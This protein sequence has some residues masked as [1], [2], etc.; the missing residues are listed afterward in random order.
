MDMK[1]FFLYAIVIAALAL[2]GCGGNGGGGD[3]AGNGEQPMSCPDGQTGTPP[4]CVTPTP[5]TCLE[6]P[7]AANCTGFTQAQIDAATKAAGTKETAIAMESMQSAT[8]GTP[9]TDG[10]GGADAGL[11]GSGSSG[12]P[13]P[14]TGDGSYTLDIKRDRDATTVSVTVEGPDADDDADDE[15]FV[16]A[17][18]L[19]GGT[20]MHTRMMDAD[21]DG[22]VVEEVVIVTTD[23][24][25]PKAT[26]FGEVENQ[27]LHLNPA[28][29]G[30]D[31]F[32][33]LRITTGGT[34]ESSDNAIDLMNVRGPSAASP[35]GEQTITYMDE[36]ETAD[37][38]ERRF[39]GTYNGAAGTYVCTGTAACTATVNDKG[40]VSA[41]GGDWTFT[42]DAGATSDV[43]D[44]DYLHYGFWLK[45]TKDKDGVFTY[46]EVETFADASVP[47]SGNITTVRG[48]ATYNGGATGVYV[49]NV[50][51]SSGDVET[52]TSGHFTATANLTATFGQVHQGDDPADDS[53]PGT[54]APNMLNMLTGT[55]FDFQLSGG[56]MNNW[57]AVLSGTI[58]PSNGTVSG[59]AKGGSPSNDGSLSAT[60]HGGVDSV[61][62][63][64]PKPGSVVG[65][66]NSFFSDGSAAGAFGARRK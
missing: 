46:N 19:G 16:Q 10:E 58:T 9:G 31:D 37:V 36:A 39:T 2:A 54:I 3:M 14:A 40:V 20:T 45:K 25:A 11:G 53:Q 21:D 62:G 56:E 7:D 6:D 51:S 24:D 28:T 65:E 17:M 33:S 52:A 29:S 61:N 38:D 34:V 12:T 57:K 30:G 60:F 50:F 5:P 23:I 47:A 66:F 41:M 42:P 1:R 15:K 59:T 32:R 49:K 26:N 43:A 18:D 64:I 4:N 44:V 55:I 48:T 22:N 8:G 35:G 63:V 27:D 13:I